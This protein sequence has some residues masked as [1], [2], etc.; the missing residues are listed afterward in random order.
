MFVRIVTISVVLSFL[1]LTTVI[2]G[3]GCIH[4]YLRVKKDNNGFVSIKHRVRV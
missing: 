4:L 3:I 2:L 1:L